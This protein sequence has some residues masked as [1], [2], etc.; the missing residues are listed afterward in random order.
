MSDANNFFTG[1]SPVKFDEGEKRKEILREILKGYE[2]P[3]L[4]I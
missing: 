3:F 1:Q 2:E 4:I